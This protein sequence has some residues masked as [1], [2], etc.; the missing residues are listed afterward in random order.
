MSEQDM[1]W[2]ALGLFAAV[3]VVVATLLGLIIAAA[4]R[5][6]RQAENIW[7]IG[8]EIAGNTVSIWMLEPLN[9][10]LER[11]EKAAG[12]LEA[13]LRSVEENLSPEHTRTERANEAG[14]EKP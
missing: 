12:T 2:L 9:Q 14:G 5:I 6:D 1:W 8:K 10:N 11:I 13:T 4:R 7:T 3:V